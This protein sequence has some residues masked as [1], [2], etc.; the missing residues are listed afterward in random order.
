MVKESQGGEETKEVAESE[1]NRGDGVE[2]EKRRKRRKEDRRHAAKPDR[3]V[4]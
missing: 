3:G 4:G 1:I 2:T